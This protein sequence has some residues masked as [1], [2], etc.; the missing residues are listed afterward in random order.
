MEID[1]KAQ[2]SVDNYKLMTGIVV[3]RPIAWVTTL[4]EAGKVNLAPFSAFTFVSHDPSMIAISIGRKRELL[5]DTGQNILRDGEF[6]INI[7]NYSMMQQLHDSSANYQPEES[8]AEALNLEVTNSVSV[9]PPRLRWAPASMECKLHM[10][11]PL[12][13]E[14]DYLIIGHVHRFHIADA[15]LRDGKIDTRSLDPIAR[16]GGPN[17]AALG[18]IITVAPAEIKSA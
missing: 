12:G 3:P 18:E 10:A 9:R 11:I 15:I 2:K 17:Y 1:P 7:A 6:V 16:L 5:K 13:N 4:N 14:R 8:E